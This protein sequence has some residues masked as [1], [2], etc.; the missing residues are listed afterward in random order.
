MLADEGDV[1]H[2][3]K[4]PDAGVMGEIRRVRHEEDENQ[5]LEQLII[6]RC[7]AKAHYHGTASFAGVITTVPL[8]PS[9]ALSSRTLTGS[10]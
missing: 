5:K 1:F 10:L 4:K 3:W 7:P 9:L 2:S 8:G 6:H